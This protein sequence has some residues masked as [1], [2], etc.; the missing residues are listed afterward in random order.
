MRV[1]G[2]GDMFIRYQPG[3]PGAPTVLLLHGWLASA[4]VNWIGVFPAL[5][6]R[7]HVIAVDHRGH[8]RGIRTTKPIT[9]EDCADDAA[10]LVGDLGV[11]GA[12]VA[13]YSMGGP[14]ALDMA[15]RH[16][17]KVGGLVL[18]ATAAEMGRTGVDRAMGVMLPVF[19]ALL[20]S[21]LTDR[22]MRLVAHRP[23]D[24]LGEL[25]ELTPWLGG[26]MKRIHPADAVE[27]GRSLASFDARPWLAELDVTAA[28]V[29]TTGDRAVR[30][31]KQQALAAALDAAVVEL[32]AG[33]AACI[34]KAVEFGAAMRVAVDIVGD[35]VARQSWW[36][37]PATPARRRRLLTIANRP[38][39]VS[40]QAAD[41]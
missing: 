38:P 5:A 3:P 28:S 1:P 37:R 35:K 20:R 32:D 34:N 13:G 27:L 39:G 21:G 36:T 14:I 33:H 12:I 24:Q 8:G 6:G 18:A 23:A 22:A 11:R 17:S 30:P 31:S 4:D 26:E 29:I 15:R 9:I 2:R 25:A 40:G 16:R 41:G 10:A 19:G 7:Y